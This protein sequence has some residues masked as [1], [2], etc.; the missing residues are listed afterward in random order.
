VPI[1]LHLQQEHFTH[2]GC[3]TVCISIAIWG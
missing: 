2:S 1:L 3:Q